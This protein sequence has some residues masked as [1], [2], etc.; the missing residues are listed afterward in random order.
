VFSFL[1]QLP[2]WHCPHTLL[3]SAW[4]QSIDISCPPDAQQ[5]TVAA[6]AAGE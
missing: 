6:V 5:Q 1:R 4:Q 3:L 2:T